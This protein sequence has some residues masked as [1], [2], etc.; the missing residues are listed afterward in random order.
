MADQRA[1]GPSPP[2]VLIVGAG[3]AGLML[4]TLFER[5]NIPYHIF[6]RASE[7]RPLGAVMGM[8]ADI[9][10]VFEQLG[11]LEEVEKISRPS[12]KLHIYNFDLTKVGTKDISGLKEVSGYDS[13]MFARP[14]LYEI[15]RKQ[16]PAHKISMNKKV[17]RTE[18]KDDR[19][20]IHFSDN[21]V[22][23]GDILVGADGSYSA[24]RQSMYKRLNEKGLL[25]KEDLEGFQIGYVSMVGVATPEDP[26]KYPQ[27][28]D[29]TSNFAKVLGG[30]SRGWGI[31]NLPNNQASWVLSIQLMSDEA[32]EQQFRNSEWGP[33]A[34]ESM[35]KEFQDMPNPWGGT[36]GDL[37][38]ATPK[39]LI[40]KVYLE[41]KIFKTWYHGRTVLI[42]DACHKMLP[43]GG[44]GAVNA[45]QDA[46]V[47]A[48]CL[49][50]MAD[51]ST[52]SINAAFK[53]YYKQRFH[54]ADA[55]IA[56]SRALAKTTMEK[57][58]RQVSLKTPDWVQKRADIKLYEYRPQVAWLPL[59]K[60][61]GTGNVLPQEGPRRALEE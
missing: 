33:E 23:E 48:N 46:V 41:E 49:F 2:T 58:I 17:L 8:G 15:M 50:S 40:S 16:V 42:G 3:L 59:V 19:V 47:L 4:G 26:E 38:E 51:S 13:L 25:P 61:R 31:F 56:R 6:E 36:M 27:L 29:E 44:Q 21:T 18:E 52:E 20:I 53:E 14:R 39:H 9:L 60:P 35:I 37:I 45:M 24:V 5:I 10:P 28:K 54:R 57:I 1:E 34:N 12:S 7:V 55:E 32:R 11:L 43:S 22:C 30:A